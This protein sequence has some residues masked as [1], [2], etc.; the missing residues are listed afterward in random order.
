MDQRD[1][2]GTRSKMD[3]SFELEIVREALQRHDVTIRSLEAKL[4]NANMRIVQLEARLQAAM[5]IAEG[6]A[7]GENGTA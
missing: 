6:L 1:Q 7:R 2:A 5:L 4:R 3:A